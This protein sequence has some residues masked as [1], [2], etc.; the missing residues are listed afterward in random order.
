MSDGENCGSGGVEVGSLKIR[1]G[2]PGEWMDEVAKRGR[3]KKLSEEWE[4]RVSFRCGFDVLC[5][6]RRKLKV[7][8]AWEKRN[9]N[10]QSTSQ[11]DSQPKGY[12]NKTPRRS[13]AQ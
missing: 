6:G 11:S 5:W 8:Y 4:E 7:V 13:L 2:L 10:V 1:W 3:R 9:E 12:N